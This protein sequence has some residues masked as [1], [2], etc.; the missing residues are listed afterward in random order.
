M[1]Y[2]A[3]LN[4]FKRLVS[5]KTLPNDNIF[6]TVFAAASLTFFLSM[7]GQEQAIETSFALTFCTFLFSLSLILNSIYAF[8]YAVNPDQS[9][10]QSFIDSKFILR[11]FRA[12][13]QWSFIYAIL[14]L[15]VHFLSHTTIFN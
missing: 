6:H 10:V 5:M 2:S 15:I 12:L 11:R 8:F 4:L 14:A 13:G 3:S 9:K 7:L 1:H